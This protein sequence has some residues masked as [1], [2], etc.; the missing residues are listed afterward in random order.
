M[1]EMQIVRAHTLAVQELNQTLVDLLARMESGDKPQS[2]GAELVAAIAPLVDAMKAAQQTTALAA[3]TVNLS[4][5]FKSPP[6]ASWSVKA[7]RTVDGFDMT[8]TKTN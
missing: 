4:A 2:S 1:D 3:P 6:G 7:K 8:V 5:E